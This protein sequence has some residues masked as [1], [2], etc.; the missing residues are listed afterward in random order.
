MSATYLLYYFILVSKSTALIILER[1]GW[2]IIV[3]KTQPGI[4]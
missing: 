4:K 2:L 3:Q 1:L